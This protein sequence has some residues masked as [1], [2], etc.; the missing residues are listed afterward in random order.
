MRRRHVLAGLAATGAALPFGPARAQAFPDHAI[1]L[2]VPFA[3]GGATDLIGRV[4]GQRLGAALGTVVVVDNRG[5][6]GGVVGTEAASKAPADGYTL[7]MAA[8]SGFATG[9]LLRPAVGYDPIKD[10]V[11]IALIGTFANAFVVRSDHPIGSLPAFIAAAKQ[12]PGALTYASAGVGSAGHLTGAL[13]QQLAGIDITHVPYRGTAPAT[14]DLLSGQIDAMFDGTPTSGALLRAGKTRLLAVTGDARWSSFP[15][16]PAMTEIVPG[17]I[18]MAWF[19]ISAPAGVPAPVIDRLQHALLALLET[20]EMR[21]QI[22]ELGME[23]TPLGAAAYTAFIRDDIARWT[24]VI[25]SA[26]IKAE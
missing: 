11:H 14:T 8:N 7:L 5:G 10:F 3:A 22:T 24:P 1:R 12:K 15:E 13:F 2:I 6:A 25:R 26:G 18:G 23:P 16:A 20:P 9:P 17:C 19:G 4:V 21:A